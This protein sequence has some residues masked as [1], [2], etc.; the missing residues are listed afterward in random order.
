MGPGWI[1]RPIEKATGRV[2][3]DLDDNLFVETPAMRGKGPLARWLYGPQQVQRVLERADEVIVSTSQL[4]A[5]LGSLSK[6]IHVI[7][8]LPEVSKY[9]RSVQSLGGP[10]Q[11]VWA[12]TRGGLAYL[13]FL[14]DELSLLASEGI[15]EL[16][17]ICSEPWNGP[18]HFLPW[19]LEGEEARLA[20]F[21]VGI[22]PL[23]D[24]SYAKSKAGYKLLQYMA[25][26]MP[27]IASPIGI[28]RQLVEQSGAGYLCT[29]SEEWRNAI[30]ELYQNR[31]G[32]SLMGQNGLTFL[33]AY[34][35]ESELDSQLLRVIKPS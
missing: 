24:T 19:E 3:L 16:T 35:N 29:T 11:L 4:A 2:I 32:A 17:V 33:A 7:P 31:S 21:D 1:A 12:G 8:T 34:A 20:S 9:P 30:I 18:A 25:T 15:A 23:P 26:G 6:K 13:D 10:M 27:V 5:E 14:A 28:N 22:M